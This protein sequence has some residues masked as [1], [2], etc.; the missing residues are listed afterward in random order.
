MTDQRKILKDK[1]EQIRR[2]RSIS[3][4]DFEMIT[5]M[6]LEA[7]KNVKDGDKIIEEF[8]LSYIP[9]S[10]RALAQ[11]VTRLMQNIDHFLS[12]L[13][14]KKLGF[15]ALAGDA[16]LR[17]KFEFSAY[18]LFLL[19]VFASQ[20]QTPESRLEIF[21]TVS[22]EVLEALQQISPEYQESEFNKDLYER[23][24]QYAAFVR[25]PDTVLKVPPAVFIWNLLEEN[26]TNAVAKG[27]F[28]R[29]AISPRKVADL[30]G[31]RG[32]KRIRNKNKPLDIVSVTY[33]ATCQR[34]ERGYR[35]IIDEF[36]A[37]TDD[38]RD[39]SDN[40]LERIVR[41][42]KAKIAGLDEEDRNP[43]P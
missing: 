18:L 16:E 42:L 39:L 30:L 6:T 7:A 20:H 41:E 25:E 34:A 33:G 13:G 24:N 17:A 12:I 9:H 37:A 19:D 4:E 3:P 8:K 11:T 27:G 21:Y 10:L 43:E 32:R 1:I 22:N 38:I 36:F 15:G 5:G 29:E 14:E 23:M 35:L 26:L 28:E 31:G 40:D 2:N